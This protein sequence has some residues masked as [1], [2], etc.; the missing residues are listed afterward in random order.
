MSIPESTSTFQSQFQEYVYISRYARFLHEENRR[1]TWPE[2]VKRYF[3]FMEIH[4]RL[5]CGY[6]LQSEL[7]NHL[8]SSVLNLDVMPSMRCIM[9][10]GAALHKENI[11]GFNCAYLTVDSQEAFSEMLYVLMNGTGVGF[12]VES[13]YTNKLPTI[14]PLWP[15]METIHV[16]DSKLGWAVAFRDLIDYL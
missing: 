11:A 5:N 8:E 15:I 9:T 16:G 4:L 1:E 6:N 14:P 10:A 3:D 12:S 2:T 7:R 13:E